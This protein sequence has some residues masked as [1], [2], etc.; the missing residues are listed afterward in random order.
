[1][2]FLNNRQ[3]YIY[4]IKRALWCGS[5]LVTIVLLINARH[6]FRVRRNVDNYMTALQRGDTDAAREMIQD[7][8]ESQMDASYLKK[9]LQEPM[10]PQM[11]QSGLDS[12]TATDYYYHHATSNGPMNMYRLSSDEPNDIFIVQK[13]LEKGAKPSRQTLQFALDQQ[14]LKMTLNCLK[15]GV[16]GEWVGTYYPI[17]TICSRLK[18]EYS[19][20]NIT[21]AKSCIDILIQNKVN[22]NAVIDNETPL[23]SIVSSPR[24]KENG[25]VYR[26]IIQS[27]IQNGADVNKKSN[28][29]YVLQTAVENSD[30]ET[31]GILLK[32]GARPNFLLTAW[33]SEGGYRNY[34]GNYGGQA[35]VLKDKITLLSKVKERCGNPSTAYLKENQT[36]LALLKQYGAEKP[37]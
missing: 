36:I 20:E 28:G 21:L 30:V 23:E 25:V 3:K 1:M 18:N 4:H 31:V 27:L 29:R 12:A 2:L 6:D 5:L 14:N 8:S 19:S 11:V 16:K 32:A 26:S 22:L 9:R 7:G 35:Y 37:L 17:N 10:T 24:M 13:F 15:G 34:G 33:Y